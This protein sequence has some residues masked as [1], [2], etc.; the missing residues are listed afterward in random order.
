[1]IQFHSPELVSRGYVLGRAYRTRYAIVPPELVST[2]ADVRSSVPEL[3]ST[4][5][6]TPALCLSTG[7]LA[8]GRSA[9]PVGYCWNGHRRVGRA[10]PAA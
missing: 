5:T 9:F 7:V 1:M 3:V 8:D 4:A 6:E 2:V 10:G